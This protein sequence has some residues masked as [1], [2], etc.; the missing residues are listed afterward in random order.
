MKQR[1]PKDKSKP[2]PLRT[3]AATAVVTL[4]LTSVVSRWVGNMRSIEQPAAVAAPTAT[5]RQRD[6]S[7][8]ERKI[9]HWRAPMNPAEIYDKPGK[10]AMG[11]DLIPVYEDELAGG[12]NINIDPVTQQNMGL[13]TAPVTRQP[14]VHTI[15]TYGQVTYDETRTVQISPKVSGWIETLHTRLGG[16]SVL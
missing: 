3:I 7:P 14:L 16:L 2:I 11:M 6:A 12:V 9:A 15:R 10:S 5:G 8:T 4:V 1:I 13:R